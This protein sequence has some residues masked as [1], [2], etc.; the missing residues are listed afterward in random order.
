MLA[1]PAP[2]MVT[3]S[4]G[5]VLACLKFPGGTNTTA[6]RAFAITT[7]ALIA[8]VLSADSG[9]APWSVMFTIGVGGGGSGVAGVHRGIVA[10]AGMVPGRA[11]REYSGRVIAYPFLIHSAALPR[12]AGLDDDYERAGEQRPAGVVPGAG[13]AENCAGRVRIAPSTAAS[14]L[15]TAQ[16]E[17]TL[18]LGRPR[19]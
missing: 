12:T 3:P 16:C 5:I 19:P 11:G 13:V 10:V 2:V 1:S 18:T 15:A 14:A 17:R 6:F 8:D 4:K 9:L 7:A